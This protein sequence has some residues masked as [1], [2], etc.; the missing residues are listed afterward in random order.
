MAVVA[1][2]GIDSPLTCKS[3]HHHNS[4]QAH[5]VF[6]NCDLPNSNAFIETAAVLGFTDPKG[7]A[8]AIS[9]ISFELGDGEAIRRFSVETSL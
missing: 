5:E 7:C 9:E 1:R 6:V 3:Q 4:Q 2:C 8:E